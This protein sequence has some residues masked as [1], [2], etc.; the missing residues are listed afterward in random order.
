MPRKHITGREHASLGARTWVRHRKRARCPGTGMV[1]TSTSPCSLC[2]G[3]EAS[4]IARYRLHARRSRP[5]PPRSHR[6]CLLT[7]IPTRVYTR[8]PRYSRRWRSSCRSARRG[9]ALGV[10]WLFGPIFPANRRY[11]DSDRPCS[12]RPAQA[13]ADCPSTEEHATRSCFHTRLLPAAALPRASVWA[14]GRLLPSAR[15]IRYRLPKKALALPAL[16]ARGDLRW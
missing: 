10:A 1:A 7:C 11:C 4:W 5:D 16:R 2:F 13:R 14:L 12:S 9:V 15:R 3:H 6:A 8:P